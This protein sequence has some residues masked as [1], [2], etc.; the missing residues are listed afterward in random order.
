MRHDIEKNVGVAIDTKVK[1]PVPSNS[2]L[3]ALIIVF[4]GAERWMLRI[5]E[6]KCE[7]FLKRPLN[8]SGRT[9]V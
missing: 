7:L 6:Q 8:R 1:P 9:M 4:F 2:A 5:V 3:P